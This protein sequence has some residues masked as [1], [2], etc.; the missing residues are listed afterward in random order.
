MAE[1][2][3]KGVEASSWNCLLGPAG[4]A[5]AVVAKV[6]RDAAT[7]MRSPELQGTLHAMGSE[8]ID[9]GPAEL[10]TYIRSETDKWGTIARRVNAKAE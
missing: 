4:L 5:S 9:M 2:G 7:L 10:A 3:F 1:A 6:H 8:I